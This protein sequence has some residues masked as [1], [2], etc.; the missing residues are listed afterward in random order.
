MVELG[1][2]EVLS[3]PCSH[4]LFLDHSFDKKQ[5]FLVHRYNLPNGE[6]NENK[7]IFPCLA[8]SFENKGS[9]KCVI[10]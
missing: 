8:L 7:K 3:E 6:K 4:G 10:Y 9:V 1:G 5:T 2:Y